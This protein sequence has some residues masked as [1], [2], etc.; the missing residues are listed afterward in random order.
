M[1]LADIIAAARA[2][3]PASWLSHFR[4]DSRKGTWAFAPSDAA[5]VPVGHH[6]MPII[7][8]ALGGWPRAT[9]DQQNMELRRD[10][11]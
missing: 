7:A 3:A 10:F 8:E 11:A 2:A 6:V 1:G 4:W 5:P 9:R